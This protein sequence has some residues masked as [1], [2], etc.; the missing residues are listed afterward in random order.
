MSECECVCVCVTNHLTV[1]F[2]DINLIL[3][4]TLICDGAAPS[5][6]L[7]T[8]VD[9]TTSKEPKCDRGSQF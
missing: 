7:G 2:P 5:E 4:I 1:I 8:S 9:E 6:I 3:Y